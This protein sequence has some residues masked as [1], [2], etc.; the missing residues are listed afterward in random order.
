MILFIMKILFC[1][2]IVLV[3]LISLFA[4]YCIFR[5][6]IRT[7]GFVVYSKKYKRSQR[8]IYRNGEFRPEYILNG[9]KMKDWLNEIKRWK[10]FL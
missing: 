2:C 9:E 7:N 3:L 5:S 8:F 10:F 1:L 4:L 6:E